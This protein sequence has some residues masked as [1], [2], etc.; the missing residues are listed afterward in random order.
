MKVFVILNQKGG[1]GKTTVTLNLAAVLAL[2]G[3]KVLLVDMDP[4]GNASSA[5]GVNKRQLEHGVYDVLGGGAIDDYMVY[6]LTNHYY[7]LPANAG[8]AATEVELAH[9]PNWHR[10]LADGLQTMQAQFDYVLIDCPPS[11]NIL[12]INALV[13]AQQLIIPMQ[14]EYFALEGLSDLTETLQYLNRGWNP[15]L[16]IGGIVRS[17]YDGRNRLAQEVSAELKRHFGDKVFSTAITRNV[18]LAEAP[19]YQQ[20]I[21]FYA[22]ESHGA[23]NY[24]QLGIEFL[25]R[26][27][28]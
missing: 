23:E 10:L 6:S 15:N 26:F 22:P 4:Q 25:K 12:T 18:R 9:A 7:I 17:L 3:K 24:R 28:K 21:F 16:T 8:L 1:T 14:C 19:S 20:A 2:H 11:L 5:S 27:D 13:A